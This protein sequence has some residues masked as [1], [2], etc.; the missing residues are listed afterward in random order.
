MRKYDADVGIS[1][2]DLKAAIKNEYKGK[3]IKNEYT[4]GK[5]QQGNGNYKKGPNIN[6]VTKNHY[7]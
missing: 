1:K 5:S 7:I 3:D 2:Q 4:D 6:F